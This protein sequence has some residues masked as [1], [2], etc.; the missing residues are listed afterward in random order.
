MTRK[1]T[2]PDTEFQRL[3]AVENGHHAGETQAGALTPKTDIAGPRKRGGKTSPPTTSCGT[4]SCTTIPTWPT[5]SGI[6]GATGAGFG[7]R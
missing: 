4:A 3:K 6:G 5:G 2:L 1:G 7:P